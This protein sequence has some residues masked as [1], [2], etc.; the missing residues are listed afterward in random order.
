MGLGLDLDMDPKAFTECKSPGFTT[1]GLNRGMLESQSVL[2]PRN[3]ANRTVGREGIEPFLPER[4][5]DMRSNLARDSRP[6]SLFRLIRN[7]WNLTEL[8]AVKRTGT[9]ETDMIKKKKQTLMEA[10]K[11]RKEKRNTKLNVR[12]ES[13][14]EG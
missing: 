13:P 3:P 8:T 7:I 11:T 12:Y 2:Y 6:S 1:C 9:A 10:I 5:G 14:G 4:R